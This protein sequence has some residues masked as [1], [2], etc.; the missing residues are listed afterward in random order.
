MNLEISAAEMVEI[1][2]ETNS[3]RKLNDATV[4]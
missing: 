3:S 4:V 2:K 1:S